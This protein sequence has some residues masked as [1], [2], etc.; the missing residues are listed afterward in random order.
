MSCSGVVGGWGSSWSNFKPQFPLFSFQTR[1]VHSL[2]VFRWTSIASPILGGEAPLQPTWLC[3]SSGS[4]L[5]V[6][7]ISWALL[8]HLP[9]AGCLRLPERLREQPQGA[10]LYVAEVRVSPHE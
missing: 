1:F 6:R 5:G 8:G 10:A 2:R 7:F 9:V 3:R 4:L